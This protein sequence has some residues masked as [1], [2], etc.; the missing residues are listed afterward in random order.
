MKLGLYILCALRQ[1]PH[2][3][4]FWIS[5]AVP[6]GATTNLARS[7]KITRLE[8]GTGRMSML[9]SNQQWDDD[10]GDDDADDVADAGDTGVWSRAAA[11]CLHWPVI[12]TISTTHRSA[13]VVVWPQSWPSDLAATSDLDVRGRRPV[14]PVIRVGTLVTWDHH[15]R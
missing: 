12:I 11:V 14:W 3:A 6:H 13:F 10:D 7:G 15:A 9:T 4:E 8:R 2:A 1:N 5:A